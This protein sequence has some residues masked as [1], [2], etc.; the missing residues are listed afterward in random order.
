[1]IFHSFLAY[2]IS[3]ENCYD[4]YTISFLI[5][6]PLDALRSL[7]L[8]ILFV[9]SIVAHDFILF[10]SLWTSWNCAEASLLI[11]EWFWGFISSTNDY[12]PFSFS[13]PL[14]IA[15]IHRVCLLLLSIKY[16]TFFSILWLLF[17]IFIIA[18]GFYF[19]FKFIWYCLG[20]QNYTTIVW[21]SIYGSFHSISINYFIL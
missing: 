18:S 21:Y 2:T 10:G 5:F 11:L 4:C 19:A 16:L 6:F 7:S 12:F 1:M 17:C 13:S 14:G 20:I 9:I 15:K 8:C 3:C